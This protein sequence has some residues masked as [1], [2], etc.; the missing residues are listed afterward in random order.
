MAP[1][2][3]VAI[4]VAVAIGGGCYKRQALERA[5][6]PVPRHT[7]RRVRRLHGP[8]DGGGRS[9]YG[10][11]RCRYGTR[12]VGSVAGR[13]AVGPAAPCLEF[14]VT[15][16]ATPA[17]RAAGVVVCVFVEGDLVGR[18]PVAEDVA[19][20]PAVVPPYEVVEVLLAGRLVAYRGV[21]IGL[22]SRQVERLAT[23]SRDCGDRCI[24]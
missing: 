15:V 16:G 13:L 18:V 22:R 7:L 9:D 17:G 4:V 8:G 14:G 12:R 6:V 21:R 2:S 20:A 24:T 10:T 11:C 3:V 5:P 23:R 1:H 19:T